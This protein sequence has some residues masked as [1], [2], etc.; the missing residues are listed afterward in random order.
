MAADKTWTV[1]MG[2]DSNGVEY[3]NAIKCDF[4]K[5]PR[6]SEVEY[7]FPFLVPIHLAQSY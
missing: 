6:V 5:D 2:C 7:M 3:K 4:E 1:A